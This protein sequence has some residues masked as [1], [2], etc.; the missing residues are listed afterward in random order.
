M[1]VWLNENHELVS[2]GDDDFGWMGTQTGQ[3]HGMSVCNNI[4]AENGGYA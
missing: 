2:S 3:K 4:S 1:S